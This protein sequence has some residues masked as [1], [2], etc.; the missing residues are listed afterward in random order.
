[1]D[2]LTEGV[3]IEFL[4]PGVKGGV[5]HDY[6]HKRTGIDSRATHIL[7]DPATVHTFF[8]F[9]SGL[10]EFMQEQPRGHLS[11]SNLPGQYIRMIVFISANIQPSSIEFGRQYACADYDVENLQESSILMARLKG[12]F[13]R[14]GQGV[15]A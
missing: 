6:G 1:M 3:I 10:E 13:N 4:P 14:E 7:E 12:K 5:S 15:V 8:D 9:L 2:R 11:T